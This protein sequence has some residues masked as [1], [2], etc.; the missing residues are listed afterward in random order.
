MSP[1]LSDLLHSG[2]TV[3]TVSTRLALTLRSLAET[4]PHHVQVAPAWRTPVILPWQQWLE[5]C[6]REHVIETGDTRLLLRPAQEQLLW[7]DV[8]EAHARGDADALPVDLD[9]T[10]RNVMQAWNLAQEW[11]LDLQA[12][13]WSQSPDTEGFRTWAEAFEQR[14]RE[15]DA[16]PAACLTQALAEEL[17]AG[18][19]HLRTPKLA[20]AGFEELTPAQQ[21]FIAAVR[22]GGV[23]VEVL[24]LE[25][26]PGQAGW[27][28]LR[29]QDEEIFWAARWARAILEDNQ[30]GGP[31]GVVVPELSNLR[32]RVERIFTEVFHPED[33]LETPRTGW[34]AFNLSLG[35]P[36]S[37]YPVMQG[38]LQ[39]LDLVNTALRGR[40]LSFPAASRLLR[41][42]WLGWAESE[43]TRRALLDA[44][45]RQ[46]QEID[47]TPV[48]LARWASASC[49]RLTEL[50]HKLLEWSEQAP[51]RQRYPA[52]AE[53]IGEL[54]Q[55]AGWPGERPLDSAEH[56]TVQAFYR[57]LPELARLDHVSGPVPFPVALSHLRRLIAAQVFQ[58]ESVP[59]PVQVMGL[60]E[61]S[62]LRFQ[63]L[64]VLGLHDGVWPA[65]ARPQP[66]LPLELQRRH[67]LP[68]SSA[69][70]EF[71]F[72]QRR[73]QLLLGAA[74][75]V[76]FSVPGSEGDADLHPSPLVAALPR[77]DAAALERRMERPLERLRSAGTLEQID[78]HVAPPV[79]NAEEVRGGSGIFSRQAAC[80]FQ[81][82][83]VHRLDAIPLETP[84]P[85]L[86][87]RQRGILLH[88]VMA[89]IWQTLGNQARLLRTPE[90]ELEAVIA[91]AVDGVIEEQTPKTPALRRR[92][93][94]QVERLC[95]IRVIGE[96]MHLERQ[97][98]S[99][100]VVRQESDRKVEFAG[101]AM[102]L[103]ADR[104]DEL[105]DGRRIVIDYKTG[106]HHPTAWLGARP[107]QPQ[108]PL[109]AVTSEVAP[110]ALAFARLRTGKTGFHGLA[111]EAGLLPGVSPLKDVNW[112]EQLD[113]WRQELDRLATEFRA[114]WAVVD[115]R[116]GDR[117]CRTCG[118]T[119]LCR[120]SE[121][122]E[123]A[124]GR[125]ASLD[126]EGGAHAGRR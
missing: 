16:L 95:L 23:A 54:L 35:L 14:C 55:R 103:R 117:T 9:A 64:W 62:G 34:R 30:D 42:P 80:P 90:A 110:V 97:R 40:S 10:S 124:R 28:Q 70:R 120:V 67:Q 41:S 100:R 87:A 91:A 88:E 85:G 51:R 6:W 1:A 113:E 37:G 48:W 79:R 106:E 89:Q 47:L 75:E 74:P 32:A 99:F 49:P 121:W 101:L 115:P 86:N 125:S 57:L 84:E 69:A 39:I 12:P 29:N 72:A 44:E 105:A 65:A 5:Q 92:R 123:A 38:A 73:M 60:L 107:E 11:R 25:G 50:L 104:M 19:P 111:Q 122:S 108:L 109:Y 21:Q 71:A 17:T 15:C 52:W 83:A 59:A 61:S 4:E 3:L 45:L 18:A 76:V 63:H 93:L 102:Q 13:E 8:L 94:R 31:I 22:A 96:W 53:S 27:L 98:A 119:A 58:P 24:P 114:G 7:R 116:D 66:F 20:L 82:F 43:R 78:D 56:Q 2:A 112:D 118:L 126:E 33:E 36:L 26:E 81:A 46:A 77:L 68:H